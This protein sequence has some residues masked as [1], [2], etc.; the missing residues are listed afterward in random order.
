MVEKE[1][2]PLNGRIFTEN[3]KWSLFMKYGSF[4]IE[5]SRNL[6][7]HYWSKGC[8]PDLQLFSTDG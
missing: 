1:K 5:F 4:F 2:I 7:K 8:D 3:Y 6:A